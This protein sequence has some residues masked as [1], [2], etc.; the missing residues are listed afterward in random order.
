MISRPLKKHVGVVELIRGLLS[1]QLGFFFSMARL[2]GQG[3]ED[4][5]KGVV[6]VM[7]GGA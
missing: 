3:V 2:E 1:F 7:D 4:I 5:G 6:E